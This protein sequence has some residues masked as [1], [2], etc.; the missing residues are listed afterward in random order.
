MQGA[1]FCPDLGDLELSESVIV[2][3]SEAGEYVAR[4]EEEWLAAYELEYAAELLVS[5]LVH[6]CLLKRA[7]LVASEQHPGSAEDLGALG[8]LE[9]AWKFSLAVAR[10]CLVVI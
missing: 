3:V 9:A 2:A 10:G 6:P 7:Q 5:N 1:V 8:S 4:F